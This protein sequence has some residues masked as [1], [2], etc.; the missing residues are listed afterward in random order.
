MLLH[1]QTKNTP[2]SAFQ[3]FTRLSSKNVELK[4]VKPSHI[5]INTQ[6]LSGQSLGLCIPHKHKAQPKY[7][8][9]IRTKYSPP[10]FFIFWH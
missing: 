4:R 3:R 8:Y 1:I 2:L 10:L 5:K 6:T 9:P 7:Y